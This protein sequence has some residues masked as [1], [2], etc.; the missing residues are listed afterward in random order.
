MAG[1]AE[2]PPEAAGDAQARQSRQEPGGQ[3][4][5]EDTAGAV[6]AVHQR[7]Q[8]LYG[9]P[10]GPLEGLFPHCPIEP[11]WPARIPGLGYDGVAGSWWPDYSSW[12]AERSGG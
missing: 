3:A 7:A 5:A 12:L 11:C 1:Q 9:Q 10:S 6:R 2:G 8:S 4:W